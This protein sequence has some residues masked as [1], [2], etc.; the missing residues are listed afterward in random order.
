MKFIDE[1]KNKLRYVIYMH[2]SRGGDNCLNIF[3]NLLKFLNILEPQTFLWREIF[4]PLNVRDQV[5]PMG[6]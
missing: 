1:I 5:T 6:N 4:C 2:G 3:K